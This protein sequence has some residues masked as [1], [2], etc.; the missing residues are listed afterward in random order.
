M[1]GIAGVVGKPGKDLGLIGDQW[2]RSLRH[3]GPDDHGWLTCGPD[4]FQRGRGPIV[5]GPHTLLM[6]HRRLSILDL[7]ELGWQPMST[8]D[9][10]CHITFNGEIYN[11]HELRRELEALGRE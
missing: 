11:Y 5:P 4:G 10:R 6:L 3:R 1:C 2:R 7:S 9:D 8:P